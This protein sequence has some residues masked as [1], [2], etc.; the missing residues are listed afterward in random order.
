MCCGWSVTHSKSK[1][2]NLI[3]SEI[4]LRGGAFRGSLG[5]EAS[6]FMSGKG[7]TWHLVPWPLLLLLDVVLLPSPLPLRT[8]VL[9]LGSK[10]NGSSPVDTLTWDFPASRAM[11]QIPV[12]YKVCSLK[13]SIIVARGPYGKLFIVPSIEL[14]FCTF[15][16]IS[17]PSF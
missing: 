13:D 5:P 7:S 11:K 6:S 10:S 1:C 15:F 9:Y 4:L 16:P 12:L 2:G 3:I 17:K 8:P 14:G